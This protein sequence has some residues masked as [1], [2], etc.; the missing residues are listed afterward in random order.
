MIGG[1]GWH[2]E[3]LS[4]HLPEGFWAEATAKPRCGPRKRL[5]VVAGT[6]G[7]Q[8]VAD[9]LIDGGDLDG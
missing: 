1:G 6:E 2:G 3:L 9:D 7:L 8:L 5:G 4:D